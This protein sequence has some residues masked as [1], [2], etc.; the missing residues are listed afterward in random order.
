M[1]QFEKEQFGRN[2]RIE[3][4]A[5]NYKQEVLAN[6]LGVTRECVTMWET[7]KR[8]PDIVTMARICRILKIDIMDLISD[9]V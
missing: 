8:T 2:L 6:L 5:V 3:R 4:K 7:G 1:T 9:I